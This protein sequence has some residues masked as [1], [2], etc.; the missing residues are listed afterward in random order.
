MQGRDGRRMERGR[1]RKE[2]PADMIVYQVEPVFGEIFQHATDTH[3]RERPPYLRISRFWKCPYRFGEN[4]YEP[5]VRHRIAA[6][7]QGHMMTHFHE[8]FREIVHD[9]F[10]STVF[11][12][13][14]LLLDG[15]QKC[16]PQFPRVKDVH[17]TGR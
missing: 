13:W 8:S 15:S 14:N 5:C 4:R 16:D 2:G 1:E 11:F 10:G 3:Q 7:Q 9:Q 17:K 6:C 12:R